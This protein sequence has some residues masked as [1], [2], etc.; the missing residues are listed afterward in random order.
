M[1]FLRE[2]FKKKKFEW[3][4]FFEIFFEMNFVTYFALK[5]KKRWS[6]VRLGGSKFLSSLY[7]Y[8]LINRNNVQVI[9]I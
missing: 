5:E 4:N 2:Q 9:F 1:Y 7:I 8:E 6:W 3:S